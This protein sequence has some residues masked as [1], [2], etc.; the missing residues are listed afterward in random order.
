MKMAKK[1]HDL[2][3]LFSYARSK[4]RTKHSVAP[5]ANRNGDITTDDFGKSLILNEFFSYVFTKEN[6]NSISHP[7]QVFTGYTKER[8]L[9][10][11]VLQSIVERRH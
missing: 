4:S 8:L 3:S 9:D 5:L 11:D 2:K 7:E 10:V 1:K 6:I